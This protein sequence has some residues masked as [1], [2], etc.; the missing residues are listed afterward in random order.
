MRL[1]HS[2]KKI[3][4]ND[5]IFSSKFMLLTWITSVIK[6][7]ILGY[8]TVMYTDNSTLEKMKEFSIDTL[9]KEINTEVIDG[10]LS[11]DI[12]FKYFWAM[13]KIISYY[14]DTVI[15]G[16]QA[17]AIDTDLILMKSLTDLWKVDAVVWS[18]KEF[19]EMK[20]I[21]PD[22][23]DISLPL[24]YTLPSWFTGRVRP[25]NTGI[26]YFKNPEH[27]KEY[28]EEVFRWTKNNDNNKKNTV[29]VTMCNAEQRLF[30]EFVQYKNLKV[31]KLLSNNENIVNDKGFHA[32][33]WKGF[34]KKKLAERWHLNLLQIIKESDENY[35][36][37]LI[38]HPF[39]AKEKAFFNQPNYTLPEVKPL[40]KYLKTF[41]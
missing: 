29:T 23:K 19:L 28:A 30:G 13:P 41:N 37:I 7:N 36:N 3:Y 20:S 31:K 26:L 1:I 17:V 18:R 21:Y 10:P 2:R 32:M 16:H 15:L 22:I 39:F 14:Y 38:N 35:F 4:E 5:A 6:G 27:T 8:E 12:N 24:N 40:Q 34:L 33:G 11:K 9:Y 25:Y